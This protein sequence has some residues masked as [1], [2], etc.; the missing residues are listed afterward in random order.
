[1]I[2]NSLSRLGRIKRPCLLCHDWSEKPI[3]PDCAADLPWIGPIGPVTAVTSG[4]GE[5]LPVFA[6]FHYRYPVDRAIAEFKGGGPGCCLQGLLALAMLRSMKAGIVPVDQLLP[7]PASRGH[8]RRR[9]DLTPSIARSLSQ[10]NIV[11]GAVDWL[12]GDSQR[13][14]NAGSRRTAERRFRVRSAELGQRVGLVDDI[15]T[16][17]ASLAA[18]AQAC[19]QQGLQP[20]WAWVIAYTPPPR[21][22]SLK[23]RG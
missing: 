10:G 9:W 22:F 15:C 16:T 12:S 13:G 23:H 21:G 2:L 6:A 18:L 4:T 11:V 14:R 8:S 17:G 19:E 20:Q 1:M 3:C 7:L 5:S